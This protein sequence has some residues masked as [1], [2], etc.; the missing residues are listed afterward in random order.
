MGKHKSSEN[1][2]VGNKN[3]TIIWGPGLRHEI[4]FSPDGVINFSPVSGELDVYSCREND[5]NTDD[6]ENRGS[7]SGPPI[8]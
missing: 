6:G 1:S 7:G 5:V 4:N 3:I 8:H 2:R